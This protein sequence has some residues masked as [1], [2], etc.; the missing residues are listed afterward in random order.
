MNDITTSD[1]ANF[2]SIE[3]EILRLLDDRKASLSAIKTRQRNANREF[4]EG[5][6]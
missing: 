3:T 6:L 5:E 1:N 2:R 4:S